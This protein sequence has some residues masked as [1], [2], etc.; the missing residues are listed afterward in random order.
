MHVIS[1]GRWVS[2]KTSV[3]L[4]AFVWFQDARHTGCFGHFTLYCEF[5]RKG[6]VQEGGGYTQ[7]TVNDIHGQCYT[8]YLRL[9]ED[10]DKF[11]NYFRKSAASFDE[12]LCHKELCN[13]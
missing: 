9:R 3:A 11:F 8:L 5:L 1:N 7:L 4:R 2:I 6:I 13:V 10:S 12:L